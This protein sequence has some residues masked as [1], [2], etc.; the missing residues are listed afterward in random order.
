MPAAPASA[1]CCVAAP[2]SLPLS[3]LSVSAKV[4]G[5]ALPS[6]LPDVDSE[7]ASLVLRLD[8]LAIEQLAFSADWRFTP[9]SEPIYLL[10]RRLRL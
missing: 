5:N 1:S 10:T 6:Y 3:I 7:V 2:S 8:L 4:R 9:S